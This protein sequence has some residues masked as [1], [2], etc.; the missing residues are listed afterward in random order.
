MTDLP[1]ESSVSSVSERVLVV[2]GV[3]RSVTQG[4]TGTDLFGEDRAV[5][6]VRVDGELKDLV[7]DVSALPAGSTVEP[8]RIDSEDGL[9]ILRHSAA[10]VLAQAV[11]QVRSDA[12][13]GIGPPITDG[14]Y[15]DFDVETPFTPEDLKD[16]EKVMNRIIRE[17]QTFVRRVVTDEA[18][19]DEVAE[20]PYLLVLV[21]H[22]G[23]GEDGAAEG[24]C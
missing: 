21:G 9:A 3:E 4:T 13:L 19:R 7:T 2:D 17:G 6:A 1:G 14:F 24:A 5:V 8:V 23:S 15:Y 16:L 18:P 22:D 11:Q 12:K 20:E 10:H